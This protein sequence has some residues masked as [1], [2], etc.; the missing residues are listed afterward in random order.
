MM[1]WL[2]RLC[3]ALLLA[4]PLGA[5]SHGGTCDS[6]SQDSDCQGGLVCA[7]FL[8]SSKNVVGKRCGSG[9]GATICRVH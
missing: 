7:N 3:L 8:D 9:V 5:C 1:R 6:C 4:P 2:P